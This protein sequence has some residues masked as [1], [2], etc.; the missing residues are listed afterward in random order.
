VSWVRVAGVGVVVDAVVCVR[1]WPL[2]VSS[3]ACVHIGAVAVQAVSE[4]ALSSTQGWARSSPLWLRVLCLHS[5]GAQ[6]LQPI[7]WLLRQR[8]G[9]EG[10]ASQLVASTVQG[11]CL[12]MRQVRRAGVGG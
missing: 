7:V 12:A 11:E 6:Q 3:A 4:W 9:G 2:A 8:H 5:R 10:A 1:T